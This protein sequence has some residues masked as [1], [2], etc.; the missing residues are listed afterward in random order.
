MLFLG[1]AG[2]LLAGEDS[3]AVLVK[4]KRSDDH[5]GGVDW[6]VGLLAVGLFLHDFLNVDAPLS[7]VNLNDLAFFACLF[8]ALDLDG[9]SVADWNTARLIFASKLF[10]QMG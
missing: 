6:E 5:V 9:I 10:A 1:T 7:A 3:L 2:S 8:T 4:S